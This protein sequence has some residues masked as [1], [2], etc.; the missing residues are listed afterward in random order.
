MATLPTRTGRE[1]MERK[2]KR[3]AR[4]TSAAKLA[5]TTGLGLLSAASI[6]PE[7]KSGTPAGPG[8]PAVFADYKPA[9]EKGRLDKILVPSRPGTVMPS[10][11]TALSFVAFARFPFSVDRFLER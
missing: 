6:D 10:A 4:E 2:E 8:F 5:S 11:R 9:V 1:K 7:L 3:G